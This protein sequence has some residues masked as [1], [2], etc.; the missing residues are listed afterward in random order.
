MSTSVKNEINE[1][2]WDKNKVGDW[3]IKIWNDF[4]EITRKK[5]YKEF[6]SD[7]K[8]KTMSIVFFEYLSK[9]THLSVE[10]LPALPPKK[11]LTICLNEFQNIQTKIAFIWRICI[12]SLSK[13]DILKALL[14]S[15]EIRKKE[16]LQLSK[17]DFIPIIQEI[18]KDFGIDEVKFCLTTLISADYSLIN[19]KMD[20]LSIILPIIYEILDEGIEKLLIFEKKSKKDLNEETISLKAEYDNSLTEIKKLEEAIVQYKYYDLKSLF[21]QLNILFLRFIEIKEKVKEFDSQLDEKISSDGDI[22]VDEIQKLYDEFIKNKNKSNALLEAKKILNNILNIEG[23]KSED[24]N[25]IAQIRE[26]ILKKLDFIQQSENNNHFT[27]EI[28][29][30]IAEI[31]DPEGPY[32]SLLRL[33]NE[34][35]TLNYDE[36]NRLNLKLDKEFNENLKISILTKGIFQGENKNHNEETEKL[37]GKEIR[38]PETKLEQNIDQSETKTDILTEIKIGETENKIEQKVAENEKDKVDISEFKEKKM[39]NLIYKMIKK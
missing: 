2:N 33:V 14:V 37:N 39:K 17:E 13:Q 7:T 29:S 31:N 16:T 26:K 36:I 8:N 6:V 18:I 23:V 30:T 34:I 11:Y 19:I 28:N 24:K 22:S 35:E 27:E 20:N 9:K 25:V 12:N 5:M 32:L 10:S 15:L 21:E 4:E 38:S 3:L 1:N